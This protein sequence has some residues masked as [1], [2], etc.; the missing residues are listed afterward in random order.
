M[1]CQHQEDALQRKRVAQRT[2]CVREHTQA[3]DGGHIRRRL[4]YLSII[5]VI[6]VCDFEL[7]LN[8]KNS[9]PTWDE[10]TAHVVPPKFQDLQK[11]RSSCF[12][13]CQLAISLSQTYASPSRYPLEQG[14]SKTIFQYLQHVGFHQA[15][16]SLQRKVIVLISS[17]AIT[18]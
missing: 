1:G 14:A 7:P 3:F 2:F 10:S 5:I 4:S 16:Y 13:D 11:S 8:A 6:T 9:R 15:P 18:V 17:L 12:L